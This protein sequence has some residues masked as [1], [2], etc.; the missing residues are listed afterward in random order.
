MRR[1]SLA[2]LFAIALRAQ[3]ALYSE[4][5][6]LLPKPGERFQYRVKLDTAVSGLRLRPDGGGAD[7]PFTSVGNNI[8][9]VEMTAPTLRG[10]EVYSR[11]LGLLVLPSGTPVLNMIVKVSDGSMPPVR[12]TRLANDLQRSDYVV[13]VSS[14][15]YFATVLN[16]RNQFQPDI[17]G[18]LR[19][20]YQ[21]IGDDYDFVHFQTGNLDYVDNRYH[22]A[23]KNQTSGIGLTQFD[24]SA[25]FGARG[26]M[27]GI[28]VF[29]NSHF[30][31]GV[32]GSISHELGHQWIQFVRD[33][34]LEGRPHWPISSMATGIMGW[35]DPVSSQGLDF[36]C[37]LVDAGGGRYTVQFAGAASPMFNDFDL[38]LMGVI[39]PSEV[40]PQIV[41]TSPQKINAAR[42]QGCGGFTGG[43]NPGEYRVYTIDDLLQAAQPRNPSSA[44]SQKS[45]R[46]MTVVV[47]ND[48]LLNADEMAYYEFFAR[49]IEARGELPTSQGVARRL[50]VPFAVSTGNRATITARLTTAGTLPELTYGG[51]VNAASFQ[52]SALASGTVA[53]IFGTGLAAAETSASAVPLPVSLGGVRVYVEG[54]LAPLFYVSPTQINFQMPQ[55]LPLTTMGNFDRGAYVNVRVE[56]DGV[57]S[58][59]L[60]PAVK[61]AG[62]GIITYGSNLAVAVDQRGALV[63]TEN[64]A[65]PG[66]IVTVYLVGLGNLSETVPAG[67][68]APADRLITV[69]GASNVILN[70]LQ[71]RPDFL[72]LT[73]AGVGLGQAN[74]RVPVGLGAG[75]FRLQVQVGTDRS[76]EVLLPVLR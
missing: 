74:F 52:E 70:G 30:I 69:T 25:E 35:S 49:R 37:R 19:R 36:P 38:Y 20:V 42:T 63:G 56:R 3:E 43:L 9:Q 53:T 18:V 31:D 22:F 14:T 32:D 24:N 50:S 57:S 33:P 8:W 1:L 13:N 27:A 40:R 39:P 59:T 71:I 45:F 65:R 64:P 58:N 34:G 47:S 4:Q 29:P 6:P 48:R 12:V 41:V 28:T 21:T 51:I 15:S 2:V 72:G 23:V 67:Q 46:L 61:A 5:I 75:S 76:N 73:P 7:V 68:P 54:R 11:Y 44:N 17:A 10:R 66:E 26:K 62:P 55:G 16:S 60:Y